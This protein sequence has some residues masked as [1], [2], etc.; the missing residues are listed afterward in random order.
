LSE[1][2]EFGRRAAWG[3]EHRAPMRLHR[4]GE[5]RA[6]A[7]L[8]PFAKTKGTRASARKLLILFLFR[9]LVS[10]SEK[11]LKG[12]EQSFRA[13]ARLTFLCVAKEK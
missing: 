13:F 2:S 7:V 3:E 11:K 1:R 10:I 12:E 5:C 4:I 8:V 9:L 6:K